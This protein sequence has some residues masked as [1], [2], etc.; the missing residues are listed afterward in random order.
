MKKF[1]IA[2]MLVVGFVGFN[3]VSEAGPLRNLIQNIRES[4][5]ESAQA[6]PSCCGGSTQQVTK[7]ACSCGSS[8]GCSTS[9]SCGS[10]SCYPTP[11]RNVAGQVVGGVINYFTP[12]TCKNGNCGR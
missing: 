9:G 8:C 3:G 6:Q 4:R 10:G 1:M 12:S 11:V 2:V 5:C 7:S